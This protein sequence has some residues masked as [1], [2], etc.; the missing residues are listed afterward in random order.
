MIIE[1]NGPGRR[2]VAVT[3]L[4]TL[5]AY[6]EALR[7]GPRLPQ[8]AQIDPRG[9]AT[10]LHQMM[11]AEEIAPG[12]ARLRIAGT[13]Y[14]DTMGMDVRGM[15]MSALFD[16]MARPALER[17]LRDVF[18]GNTAATLLLET[19]RGLGRPALQG[20]LLLLPLA[21]D[22]PTRLMIG[23]LALHGQ[24]GRTPRRFAIRH[25]TREVLGNPQTARNAPAFAEPA[26]HFA[27]PA[28]QARHLRLVKS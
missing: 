13:L 26:A 24:T 12:L 3:A 28:P 2:A 20:Q 9:L 15:P 21:D 27:R 19:E 22:G 23:C 4:A 6:W 25:V 1:W 11:I 16:T 10:T 18:D 5:R 8:R 17:V 14:A 7:D